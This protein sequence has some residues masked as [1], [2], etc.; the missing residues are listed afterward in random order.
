[1]CVCTCVVIVNSGMFIPLS[2]YRGQRPLL[3]VGPC[4][5]HCLR[6]GLFI[7]FVLYWDYRYYHSTCYGVLG[8]WNKVLK[9]AH[10]FYPQNHLLSPRIGT[11]STAAIANPHA[12][13]AVLVEGPSPL[14]TVVSESLVHISIFPG[15]LVND[16]TWLSRVLSY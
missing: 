12:S 5:L 6:Q 15:R 11:L 16:L 7:V 14:H 10:C 3:S 13:S 4:F 1:M 2:V 9:L 8:I